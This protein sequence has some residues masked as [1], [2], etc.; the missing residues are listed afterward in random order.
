MSIRKVWVRIVIITIVLL[1]IDIWL[2]RPGNM[3]AMRRQFLTA[4]QSITVIFAITAA[5]A[6]AYLMNYARGVRNSY[7][8]RVRIIRAHLWNFYETYK[9][10]ANPKFRELL[11]DTIFPLLQLNLDA[12]LRIE[13]VKDWSS[14]IE[15]KKMIDL[16]RSEPDS[17]ILIFKYLLPLE[18]DMK[19]LGILSIRSI[20]T[21]LQNQIFTGAFYLVATAMVVIVGGT[22][23]P[24]SLI[25]D[26]M[27]INITAATVILSL[28]ELL[29]VISFVAQEIK[30]EFLEPSPQ[31]N[32]KVTSEKKEKQ[33]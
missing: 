12:W 23:L 11:Y 21:E 5:I 4:L 31:S 7:I 20:M 18:D 24:N 33:S 3:E 9:D 13:N 30:E 17:L 25:L 10:S 15:D 6:V 14:K 8:D 27:I 32:E 1:A 19:E 26:F 2:L 29:W 28:L 16:L 22:V